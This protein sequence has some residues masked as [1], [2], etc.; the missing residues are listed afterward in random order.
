MVPRDGGGLAI[1]GNIIVSEDN[2]E[3][4]RTHVYGYDLL[5]QTEFLVAKGVNMNSP[6]IYGDFIVWVDQIESDDFD[7]YGKHIS[8]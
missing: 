2:R 6:A 3:D 7:I 8:D 5:T 1:I 4:G